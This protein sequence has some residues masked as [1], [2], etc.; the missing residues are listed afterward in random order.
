MTKRPAVGP[1]PCGPTPQLSKRYEGRGKIPIPSG[2]TMNSGIP[3]AE[4]SAPTR[5]LLHS[6]ST[7][8]SLTRRLRSLRLIVGA[9]S[10]D[11]AFVALVECKP[12]AFR[13]AT[14]TSIHRPRE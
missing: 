14:Y 7:R 11:V 4:R 2:Q 5:T 10:N 3:A 13:L 8:S 9:T 6:A 12:C 1:S